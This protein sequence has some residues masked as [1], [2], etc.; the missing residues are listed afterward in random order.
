M[1]RKKQAAFLALFL[2]AACATPNAAPVRTIEVAPTAALDADL[3]RLDELVLHRDFLAVPTSR[4]RVET[5]SGPVDV[6]R[7]YE[8]RDRRTLKLSIGWELQRSR[9]RI[10]V[11]D[12]RRGGPPARGLEC[13]KYLEIFEDVSRTFGPARVAASDERCD[14]LADGG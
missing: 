6:L 1:I 13:R 4:D 7:S 12:L 3:K 9:Y 10:F 5:P 11:T 14:P 8:F 2:L